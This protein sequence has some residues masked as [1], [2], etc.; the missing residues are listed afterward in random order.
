MLGDAG[1][2]RAS[3]EPSFDE[4]VQTLLDRVC[5]PVAGALRAQLVDAPRG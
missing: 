2:A 5:K 4:M 3:R 1:S